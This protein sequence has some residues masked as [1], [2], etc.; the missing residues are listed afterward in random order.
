MNR[1]CF[2]VLAT[3]ATAIT[4]SQGMKAT[5]KYINTL[6]VAMFT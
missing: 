1:P 6:N 5:I 4:L 2:M 3:L